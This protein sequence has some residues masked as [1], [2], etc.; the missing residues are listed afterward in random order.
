MTTADNK[1]IAKNTL[2]LYFR[3]FIVMGVQLYTVR[4]VLHVLG[5]VNYGIY[6]VVA[7]IVVLLNFLTVTMSSAT[8]RFLTYEMGQ[9]NIDRLRRTFQSAL[10][11]HIIVA[12]I[13][14][15]IAETIGLWFVVNRLV[16]PPDRLS[17]AVI[18]Y[19][20]SIL[21]IIF[22]TIQV[23]FNASIISNEKMGI[24]AQIEIF[25]VFIILGGVFLLQRIP[26]DKLI[27]YGLLIMIV[28]LV[29]TLAYI[30]YGLRKFEECTLRCHPDRAIIKDLTSYSG[31]D[32][33]GNLCVTARIQGVNIILN[34]FFGPIINAATGIS[35]AVQSAIISFG[36][37]VITA[38]RP[39][40]IKKYAAGQIVEMEMLFRNALKYSLLLFSLFAV[41][42]YIEMPF[43]LKVWLGTPP[44]S[45]V[46]I[47]R[48]ALLTAFISFIT[49]V[50][51]IAVHATGRII[52]LSFV[53]GTIFLMILP[54]SYGALFIWERPETAYIVTFCMVSVNV[55]FVLSQVRHKIPQ[56]DIKSIMM[57]SFVP[58]SL[59]IFSCAVS[60]YCVSRLMTNE[61]IQ[62]IVVTI[63]FVLV[64][65][66]L[67]TLFLIPKN[68][69]N[70]VL[71]KIGIKH[72]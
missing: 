64:L 41:P 47:T 30:I 34:L 6:N 35:T 45:T 15:V 18:V 17:A 32:L 16:I 8:S 51:N 33:Y 24:Y 46:I 67:S 4:V 54:L 14:L 9:G 68:I 3:M 62:C 63:F 21:T 26:G 43:I 13:L 39:Q 53:G 57:K 56:I 44:E 37:N 27:F 2:F 69:T 25:N 5:D 38:F 12:L 7:G 66:L 28:A 36:N 60:A 48:I 58:T 72:H 23:P 10:F 19:Q 1:R 52:A 61:W 42:V 31:W 70:S 22:K 29:T 71:C 20:L 55:L 11:L 50:M 59:I 40:I 65:V 49:S